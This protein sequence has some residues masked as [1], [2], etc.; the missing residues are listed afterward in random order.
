MIQN[1][2]D[3]TNSLNEKKSSYDYG[4]AMLYLDFPEMGEL[5]SQIDP[6]DVYVDEDDSTFGL[7]NEPHVT[8]LYGLH[9]DVGLDK[10]EP[11]VGD[12]NYTAVK[13]HNASLFKNPKYDV[14]KFDVDGEMLHGVN[15]ELAE[16]PHTTD[17]PDYHPHMTVAYLK[18]GAGQ[19]YCDML[20]DKEYQLAPTHAI[21]SAP[22]G[23]K[24]QINIRVD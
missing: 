21:Y 14:L 13:A 18:P 5:H 7:E 1:F 19:K 23:D 16:L 8:L 15:K 11:I 24:H 10:I 2:K 12:K 3:F 22:S 4:C 17:Y 6:E 20:K 9:D